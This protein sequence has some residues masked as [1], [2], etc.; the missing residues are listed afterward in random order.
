M[1]TNLSFNTAY[2]PQTN[3]QFERT[4]QT[5]EDM[6]RAGVLDFGNERDEHLA[7]F[8]ITYNNSYHSGIGMTPSNALYGCSFRTPVCWEEVGT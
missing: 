3:G 6:L 4:I 8:K 5:L 2:Q 1:G 7:L